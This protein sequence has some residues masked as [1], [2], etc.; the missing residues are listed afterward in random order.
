MMHTYLEKVSVFLFILFV[1]YLQL[2]YVLEDHCLLSFMWSEF[3][4]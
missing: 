4:K 3:G 1:Y 2:L